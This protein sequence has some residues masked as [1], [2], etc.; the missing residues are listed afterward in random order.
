[1]AHTPYVPKVVTRDE[2]INWLLTLQSDM[3]NEVINTCDKL[4]AGGLDAP[5]ACNVV[6]NVVERHR[7][8]L[9]NDDSTRH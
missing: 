9:L 8:E 6:Y 5:F 7:A 3:L 1:M 4:V 2:F